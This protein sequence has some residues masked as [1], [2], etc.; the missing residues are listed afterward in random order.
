[1]IPAPLFC[2]IERMLNDETIQLEDG[3]AEGFPLETRTIGFLVFDQNYSRC[4]IQDLVGNLDMLNAHSGTHLHFFLCGVSKYGMNEK[5]DK[6]LGKMD[7]VRLYHNARAANSFIE[8]FRRNIPGW[9]YDMGLDLVLVDVREDNR[10][11]RELDFSGAVYFRV[12][13]LI[14][15]KIVDR[16][17][18]LLGK[19]IKFASEDRFASAAE[20]RG[21]LT[22]Q[23]GTQWLQGFLLAMFPKHVRKLMR[24]GTTLLG[25]TA[26][27]D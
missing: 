14:K 17:S 2:Y 24:A 9:H 13:E 12:E 10:N 19:F 26:A 7:G 18:E 8:A 11:Q 22:R 3:I 4:P 21:E 27:P 6:Y 1:M 5:G 20:F 25:G 23:Y 15:Q 16:P